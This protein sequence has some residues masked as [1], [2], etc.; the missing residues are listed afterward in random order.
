[1]WPV[2]QPTI[3]GF[4]VASTFLNPSTRWECTFHLGDKVLPSDSYIQIWRSGLG[5]QVFDSHRKA[6]LL[7]ADLEHYSSC[8][9]EDLILKLKWHTIT[10]SFCSFELLLFLFVCLLFSPPCFLLVGT[11][12]LVFLNFYKCW[13]SEYTNPRSFLLFSQAAQMTHV[14]EGRLKGVMEEADKEKVLKQ[15]TKASLNEKTLELNVV[16]R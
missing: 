5:V 4:W 8:Q 1:M 12:I 15:V 13:C 3:I 6:L 16:E 9:D 14:V 2:N 11:Y 10:V 7:P